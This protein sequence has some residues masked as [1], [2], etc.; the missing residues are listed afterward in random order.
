MCA[1]L[2]N[3]ACIDTFRTDRNQLL[4]LFFQLK[5][6]NLLHHFLMMYY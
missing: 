5:P 3:D 4:L 1:K 6:L 2:D